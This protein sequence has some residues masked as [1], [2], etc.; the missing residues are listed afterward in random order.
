MRISIIDFI[1]LPQRSTTIRVTLG[2]CIARYISEQKQRTPSSSTA[3][4]HNFYL[5]ANTRH[6]AAPS[7]KIY[8]TL[9]EPKKQTL[10]R[11][12]E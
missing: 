10:Y 8:E 9:C 5:S 7:K 12:H 1:S 11:E 2:V 6:A 4:D 3:F